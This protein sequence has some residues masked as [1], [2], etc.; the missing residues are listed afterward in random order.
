MSG[1]K[2]VRDIPLAATCITVEGI[3]NKTSPPKFLQKPQP[4]GT[5][6]PISLGNERETRQ[7][8]EPQWN[9][10]TDALSNAMSE[11]FGSREDGRDLEAKR[12]L[13]DSIYIL[14]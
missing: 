1:R 4:R 10:V 8:A 12:M 9:N 5:E 2:P 13:A 3:R 7:I 14:R 6:V 11:G